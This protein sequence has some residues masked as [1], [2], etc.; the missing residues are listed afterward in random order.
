MAMFKFISEEE[1]TVVRPAKRD[2]RYGL[3]QAVNC[4]IDP[5]WQG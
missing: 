2:D 5:A 3:V 1:S 4:G